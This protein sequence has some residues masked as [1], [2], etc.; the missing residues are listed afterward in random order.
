[1]ISYQCIASDGTTV[2]FRGGGAGRLIEF[3]SRNENWTASLDDRNWTANREAMYVD[4]DPDGK[5]PEIVHAAVCLMRY[6]RINGVRI[7]DVKEVS[8]LWGHHFPRMWR[9]SYYLGDPVG[10]E[11]PV[12]PLSTYGEI[13]TQSVVAAESLFDEL[14]PLFRYVEPSPANS[15]SYGHR[16]RELAILA[17]TE[18]EACFRGVLL[19]NTA[20]SSHAER[21]STK[22]YIRLKDPLKLNEWSVRLKDYPNFPDLEPFAAWNADKPT[23]SLPWYDAY[24][25]VKHDREGE[26]ARATLGISIQAIAALFIMQCAQ[27]GPQVYSPFFGNRSSPFTLIKLPT[28]KAGTLYSPD[29]KDPGKWTPDLYFA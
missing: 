18:V 26:F 10:S 20:P 29:P 14:N 13:Y 24:N 23:Q 6:R 8:Q 16:C 3:T 15:N 4:K 11:S 27:W 7:E 2:C 12:D 9:A 25:A 19:A 5:I 21:Y 22:D 17:C 1:M 28:W